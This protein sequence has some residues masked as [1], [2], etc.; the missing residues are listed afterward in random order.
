M[1]DG[2]AARPKV[3]IHLGDTVSE[4]SR[5]PLMGPEF[6]WELTLLLT[7]SAPILSGV[8]GSLTP[9]PSIADMT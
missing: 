4:A 5:Y 6:L 2:N 9:H 3:P 7:K 1:L 8:Q